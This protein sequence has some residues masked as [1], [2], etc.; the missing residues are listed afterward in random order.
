MGSDQLIVVGTGIGT[1]AYAV[2]TEEIH[3]HLDAPHVPALREVV[4]G[5]AVHRGALVPDRDIAF[6][7]APPALESLV[8]RV[9]A[10]HR[11]QRIA[12]QHVQAADPPQRLSAQEQRAAPGDRV[13]PHD[14]M[15]QDLRIGRMQL[16]DCRARLV[17]SVPASED[18]LDDALGGVLTDHPVH[19]HPDPLGQR[20]VGGEHR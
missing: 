4:R 15:R 5:S 9:G 1:S 12:F 18:G 7:P 6:L 2:D 10:Q 13:A 19:E 8:G 17:R 3:L 20:I 16:F 14:R 11:D